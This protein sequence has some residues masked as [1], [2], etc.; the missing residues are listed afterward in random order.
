MLRVESSARSGSGARTGGPR[1]QRSTRVTPRAVGAA[2]H[3][4]KPAGAAG[5]ARDERTAG[6]GSAAGHDGAVPAL[7]RHRRAQHGIARWPGTARPAATPAIAAWPAAAVAGGMAGIAM[8][9]SPVIAARA[10]ACAAADAE[11]PH[12]GQHPYPAPAVNTPAKTARMKEAAAIRRSVT[13]A[14]YPVPVVVAVAAVAV[15]ADRFA[16]GSPGRGGACGGGI[17]ASQP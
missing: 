8:S 13:S 5:A 1:R 16:A 3:A 17:L 15:V 2:A 7:S 10:A 9:A 12:A 4:S 6:A 11:A 14:F